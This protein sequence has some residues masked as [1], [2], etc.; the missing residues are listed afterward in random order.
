[1]KTQGN[2][3]HCMIY[4]A[5]ALCIAGHAF[6]NVFFGFAIG[7]FLGLS[8]GEYVYFPWKEGRLNQQRDL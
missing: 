1:M 4:L 6:H 7:I 2:L 3:I 5:I 8:F